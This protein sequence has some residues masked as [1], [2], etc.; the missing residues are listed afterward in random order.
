[1]EGVRA[2]TG[3]WGVQGGV[4][5]GRCTGMCHVHQEV[6]SGGQEG[7]LCRN[8]YYLMAPTMNFIFI[9]IQIQFMVLLVRIQRFTAYKE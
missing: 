3:G 4:G 7:L 5:T 1:M 2:G 9:Y 8:V 6:S